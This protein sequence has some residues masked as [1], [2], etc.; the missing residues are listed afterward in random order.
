MGLDESFYSS[1]LSSKHWLNIF[2]LASQ[3][4]NCPFTIDVPAVK[5][6]NRGERTCKL[7]HKYLVWSIPFPSKVAWRHETPANALVSKNMNPGYGSK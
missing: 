7:S 4:L 5:A 6:S 3:S 1:V 2:H